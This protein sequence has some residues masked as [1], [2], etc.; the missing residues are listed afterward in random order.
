MAT[1]PDPSD[2]LFS[3]AGH[4]VVMSDAIA[5]A[6]LIVAIGALL[7]ALRTDSRERTKYKHELTKE[8]KRSQ[9]R[10]E[11]INV[12]DDVER[13]NPTRHI[14]MRIRSAED[15][16]TDQITKCTIVDSKSHQFELTA[17]GEAYNGTSF[18][19]TTNLSV[20][21]G[22]VCAV[23]VVQTY[24]GKPKG[25]TVLRF[26]VVRHDNARSQRSMEVVVRPPGG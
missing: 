3:I 17:D 5:A 16:I 26:D 4:A 10:V 7:V 2:A 20:R 18:I 9:V 25:D 15:G 1:T 6:A 11:I 21:S 8:D 19:E 23:D 22:K 12:T 14:E 24:R 13:A